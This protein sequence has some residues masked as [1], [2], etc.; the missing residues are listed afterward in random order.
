MVSSIKDIMLAK[1]EV[2]CCLKSLLFRKNPPGEFPNLS[3]FK[4]VVLLVLQLFVHDPL[5]SEVD[6]LVQEGIKAV[7]KGRHEIALVHYMEAYDKGLSKDSLYF[8]LAENSFHKGAID[9]ALAFNLGI[10][11]YQ[12]KSEL[13]IPVLEQRFQIYSVLEFNDLAQNVSDTLIH[14]GTSAPAKKKCKSICPN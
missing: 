10:N 13:T 12:K 6:S 9:T 2:D 14:M 1:L 7:D 5:G 3:V 8:L 4:A 11:P